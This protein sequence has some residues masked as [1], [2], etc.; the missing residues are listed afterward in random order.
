VAAIFS[1]F[2]LREHLGWR[3]LLGMVLGFLGLLP[4]LFVKN[5]SEGG[6]FLRF[7]GREIILLFA[8]VSATYAW[9]V[10]KELM[11]K[12]YSF[13]MINGISMFCGGVLAFITSLV[14]EGVKTS[15]IYNFWPFLG[16]LLLLILLANVVF[17]NLY[18]WLLK[19][20]SITFLTFAGLLTP[21][22]DRSMVGFF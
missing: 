19:Q 9:F 7:S 21:I 2:L 11:Q 3:K 16:W 5:Y 12:N 22:L 17:Y 6:E 8:V 20:Y 4:V 13:L 14:F 18:A 1:Y 10:I 15:P